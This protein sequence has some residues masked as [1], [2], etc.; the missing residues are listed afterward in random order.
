MS[1]FSKVEMSAFSIRP[2][3]PRARVSQTGT[4]AD[5]IHEGGLYR[6]LIDLQTTSP[7]AQ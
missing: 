5:L 2:R 4:H 7:P 1:G 6:E 3:Y